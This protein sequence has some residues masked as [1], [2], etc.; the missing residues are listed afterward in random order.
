MANARDSAGRA[1]APA[2]AEA[3]APPEL[4][5]ELVENAGDVFFRLRLVPERRFEY[6]S[7]AIAA[8]TGYAPA[9]H[10]AD[11]ELIARIVH[12]A[13]R[14]RLDAALSGAV[15]TLGRDLLLRWVRR[16]GAV[17]W[18]EQRSSAVRD[19]SGR[20]VAVDG[21]ARDVTERMRLQEEAERT[22][23][24]REQLIAIVGHDLR[25]PLHAIGG[26]AL[27]L[28]RAGLGEKEAHAAARI[29]TCAGR[30]ER[31]IADLLDFARTALGGGIPVTRV[32]ASVRDVCAEVLEEFLAA[33]P[34]RDLALAPGP[35]AAA[36]VDPDRLAQAVQN[37]VA[38]ALVHG[39]RGGPVRVA[40]GEAAGRIEIAIHNR[41]RVVP[42]AELAEIFQPYR[43]RRATRPEGLGLGL[44]IARQIATAHGGSVRVESRLG[45]G[46]SFIVELPAR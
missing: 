35:G 23:R 5:R 42:Q 28:G 24:F 37:L 30:M 10:Y 3:D 46:A 19:A 41:G 29:R 25:G 32:R 17:V 15:P 16:D 34:G 18:T 8:I 2:P 21:V 9:E 4:F 14:E 22:A 43:E 11:P 31:M 39:E 12:P 44:F 27:L 36:D 13:D 45:E 33:D 1:I 20:I 6:V 26:S 38:N 7:P 40:V